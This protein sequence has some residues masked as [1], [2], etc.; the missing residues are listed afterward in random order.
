MD[1]LKN[2]DYDLDW[3]NGR[4]ISF[5]FL[6]LVT[7][8]TSHSVYKYYKAK[9]KIK[10]KRAECLAACKKMAEHLK[11]KGVKWLLFFCMSILDKEMH[12]K[13]GNLD[14]CNVTCTGT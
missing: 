2:W 14:F 3:L 1:R 13:M 9:S 4:N 5:V 11:Q 12:I 6:G 7:L 10:V 8:K